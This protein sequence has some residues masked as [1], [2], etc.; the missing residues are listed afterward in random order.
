MQ[1]ISLFQVDSF[2]DH[3]FRGNPAS[4]CLLGDW[5]DD[6]I[7]QSIATENNQSETAFIVQKEANHF[8]LR[9]FTPT[10]EVDLCGHATLAA[11]YI[12]FNERELSDDRIHFHTLSGELFVYKENERIVLNFPQWIYQKIARNSAVEEALGAPLTELYES[13][14]W[15]GVV[16][17]EAKLRALSPDFKALEQSDAGGIIV[18][19][20]AD[21]DTLDFVYRTF[22][23]N[24]GINE[25][26]VTG[27]SQCVLAP[28]WSKQLNKDH[29][30]SRQISI[31]GGELTTSLKNDRVE[32]KG[33]AA[34][35]MRGEILIKNLKRFVIN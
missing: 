5:V 29:L 28:Y 22:F 21:D 4:V 6:T 15:V 11:A 30:Q 19:A 25:D 3:I 31:R 18:T 32:I 13:H 20:K 33:S 26:P 12:L 17:S 24:L 14:D 8:A 1:K 7:L 9:W 27:S 34:L 16:A 10:K 35:Y 23:P 2:T